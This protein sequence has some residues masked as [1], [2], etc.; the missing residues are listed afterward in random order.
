MFVGVVSV[1]GPPGDIGLH[2]NLFNTGVFDTLTFEQSV[3][4]VLDAGANF[5]FA[6]FPAADGRFKNFH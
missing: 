4:G 5:L 3:G 2:A 6:F 1:K